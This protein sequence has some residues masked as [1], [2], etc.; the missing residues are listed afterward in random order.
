MKSKIIIGIIIAIAFMQCS[1]TDIPVAGHS[2]DTLPDKIA[3]P[4]EYK[5]GK[6]EDMGTALNLSFTEFASTT[7]EFLFA[8]NN[9]TPDTRLPVKQV[10]LSHFNNRGSDQLNVTWLGHSS[11]M[12]N[13]DGYKILTDPVFEKRISIFGPT[14]FNG[15]VPLDIEQIPQTNAVII[16]H[17]H[18][19][20]LNKLS[21]QG[22]RDKTDIFI[23]P[24]HV[25]ALLHDWGVPREKIVEL[26]WW[27]E[28][29]LDQKLMIAATPALHFSGRGIT[30]RNKTLWAS[31]VI[32]TP[33]HNL[34]FSGDSGYFEGFKQ[35][36]EKYGPFDMT[37]I[38]CGAYGKSWPKVHM[39][40]EQT[41]QAHLDLKGNVL[42]PI[43]WGTFN[44]A[45]HP[46][47]EP[48]ERLSIAAD[49][50]NIKVATPIVGETTLYGGDIPVARW[51]EKA[52]EVSVG[53][54]NTPAIE[55]DI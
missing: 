17:D 28:Y 18:Y 10:N 31:W 20:H 14:R 50:K 27:Q 1:R 19:D 5:D 45:L 34:F 13:I 54:N 7:W 25:G 8:G 42:H 9:R 24:L 33:F 23:V 47:Y 21:V 6:Y 43:H 49:Y 51:W 2:D 53:V 48:M 37:F 36:G 35:I 11:L 16:S 4:P 41:V 46:W 3:R 32:Q 12:I 52:L 29:K 30:D 44:L 26:D 15:D 22:L 55:K 38:E 39:F 40:P